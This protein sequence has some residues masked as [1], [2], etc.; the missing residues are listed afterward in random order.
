[1]PLALRGAAAGAMALALLLILGLL[2]DHWPFAWDRAIL[3]GLRAHGQSR[4]LMRAA[5]D[6]TALGSVPV[7][8]LIMAGAVSLLAARRLWLT[9]IATAAAGISGG[10]AVT[11]VK[12]IVARA[13][14]DL[15]PHWVD[16]SNASF[17]SGHA[18]GS[19]M[20][21]L[22]LAALATQVTQE[23]RVRHMIVILAVLLV[24]MIGVSRVYLGVHWPSDVAAGWCF[25]TL[26]ALG[27][28]WAT[29]AAR[30]SWRGARQ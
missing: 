20:V 11:L 17:P 22:T 7:L 3:T 25:G 27:W 30:E 13:R 18:A 2:I 4:A 16:V 26:W 6:V 15:V 5:V 1:M 21:Y 10:M 19:A 12:T 23:R 24:G 9:A 14:P 28:W 29:A 8:I